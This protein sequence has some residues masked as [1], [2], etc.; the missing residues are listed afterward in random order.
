MSPILLPA[1]MPDEVAVY[2]R[3]RNAKV[4]GIPQHSNVAEYHSATGLEA[5]F[6]WLW[7]QGKTDRLIELF[8]IALEVL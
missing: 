6:G 2:K 3:G 1:L 8:N 7:M 5:L 4:N